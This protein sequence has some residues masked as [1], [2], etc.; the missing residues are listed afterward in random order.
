MK[1]LRNSKRLA[2]PVFKEH[3]TLKYISIKHQDEMYEFW[4]I[5]N[6]F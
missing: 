1:N 3:G 6:T 5:K 4:I 2:R